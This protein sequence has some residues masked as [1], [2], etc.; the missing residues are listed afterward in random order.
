LLTWPSE[1]IPQF[2]PGLYRNMVSY[3]LLQSCVGS[4]FEISVVREATGV[5]S[6]LIRA[7]RLLGKIVQK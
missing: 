7:A 2:F 1:I 5:S 4:I 6:G 3:I